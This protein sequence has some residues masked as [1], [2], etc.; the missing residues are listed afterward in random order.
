M[1]ITKEQA[2]QFA[3][4][5]GALVNALD[6]VWLPNS[7]VTFLTEF[8]QRAAAYAIKQ[9]DK[10]LQSVFTTAEMKLHDNDIR[11][12]T[13]LAE[14][15]NRIA[16]LEADNLDLR[17]DEALNEAEERISILETELAD[18]KQANAARAADVFVLRAAGL[19]SLETLVNTTNGHWPDDVP[20]VIA[21]LTTA[22]EKSKT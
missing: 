5:A 17:R 7:T 8:A 2:L 10:E 22:L 19:M 15:K 4:E 1:T 3:R 12:I 18:Y 9:R 21:A 13:T 6:G 14:Y 11:H 20:E 16:A